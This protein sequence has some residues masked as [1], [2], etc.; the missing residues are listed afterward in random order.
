[1][2]VSPRD[3]SR[4]PVSIT[5]DLV[6][7]GEEIVD[8]NNSSDL[9]FFGDKVRV[10]IEE[11]TPIFIK[12][13]EPILNAGLYALSIGVEQEY[14]SN[15]IYPPTGGVIVEENSDSWLLLNPDATVQYAGITGSGGWCRSGLTNLFFRVASRPVYKEQLEVMLPNLTY[16]GA[17]KICQIT[18]TNDYNGAILQEGVD[19]DVE[20]VNN[21][22]PGTA[23][24]TVT[25]KGNYTGTFAKEFTIAPVSFNLSAGEGGGFSGESGN[26]AGYEGEY[27]GEGHG[28]TVN[29][30]ALNEVTVKYAQVE[31]GPY[32]SVA[33]TFTN[34]CNKTVW[35]ELS[36]FGYNSFTGSVQVVISPRSIANATITA[37]NSVDFAGGVPQLTYSVYD[38]GLAKA[39][40]KGKDYTAVVANDEAEGITTVT[41]SGK[42]NYNGEA[43]TTTLYQRSIATFEISLSQETFFYNGEAKR[44]VVTVTDP[45]HDAVLS[46]GVDFTVAYLDN[47]DVGTASVTVTG[48]GNYTGSQTLYYT[49]EYPTCIKD[50]ATWQYV[51]YP[52]RIEMVS[53]DGIG[54]VRPSVVVVPDEIE[55]LPVVRLPDEAFGGWTSLKTVVFGRNMLNL[56]S[57]PFGSCI[58]LK[59]VV[60]LGDAP[61]TAHTFTDTPPGLMV[62]VAK[63]STGWSLVGEALPEYWPE[64]EIIPGQGYGARA[65]AYIPSVEITPKSGVKSGRVND[66]RIEADT[67][68]I[69]A[70]IRYTLDGSDP[71]ETSST[72]KKRFSV[73][74]TELVT[75]K[76]AMFVGSALVGDVTTVKYAPDLNDVINIG[77]IVA[78][79]GSAPLAFALD[80]D[81]PWWSDETE[82]SFDGTPSMK[83]G[84]LSEEGGTSWMSA[85]FTGAGKFEFWWRASCERD[86]SGTYEYDH[87]ICELDGEEVRCIDGETDWEQV[88]LDV[89]TEGEHTITW[90]YFKDDE[91][92]EGED[93]VWV[94]GVKFSYPVT[95]SFAIGDAVGNTPEPIISAV[96]YTATLPG[97]EDIVLSKHTF[98]GWSDGEG[99]ISG[100][101]EI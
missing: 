43:Q 94:D 99:C 41:V 93:C 88:L 77:A 101:S 33:P 58:S 23:T 10:A 84:K 34:V 57:N 72:Y 70:T 17:A 80:G 12:R 18:I 83:S 90:T 22:N 55:G 92:T 71:T 14:H 76:A 9:C 62:Y 3:I 81:N 49:I 53:V 66:V 35:V 67:A 47:I 68:S 30:D 89:E 26:I 4:L 1:M 8:D 78:K 21:V 42:G 69:D 61:Q 64:A 98:G 29:V 56:G 59:S 31:T 40:V 60:F 100:R 2:Y 79:E 28:L 65:I 73:M 7:T 85:T 91:L 36:A 74:V 86:E 45:V 82:T 38:S 96:G 37:V 97:D 6:Y 54:A 75:I 16:D 50:G 87:A 46:K 5:S 95:V 15:A 11:E 32:S 24:V 19:Y 52:D 63:D 51:A 27:D 44:P 48:K 13:P 39:L 25:C 20:Y